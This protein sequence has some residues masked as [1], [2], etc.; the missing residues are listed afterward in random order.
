LAT[1]TPAN[2]NGL[3]SE[4]ESIRYYRSWPL[5][6]VL[7]REPPFLAWLSRSW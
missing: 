6:L 2:L 1:V 7:L 5:N 4:Q 3:S